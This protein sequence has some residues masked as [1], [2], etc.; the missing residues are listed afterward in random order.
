MASKS[1]IKS[2]I[3]R[4]LNRIDVHANSLDYPTIVTK[5]QSVIDEFSQA[6]EKAGI[7]EY[8]MRT[9]LSRLVGMGCMYFDQ[10]YEVVRP[11]FDQ[12]IQFPPISLDEEIGSQTVWCQ[13]L[14]RERRFDEAR[15]QMRE[16]D[17]LLAKLSGARRKW[18]DGVLSTMREE[19]NA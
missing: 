18:L 6:A 4:A 12:L 8:L 10:P 5:Y 3:G 19:L 1:K 16:L 2:G 11:F 13:Y 17:R 14:I 7:A 15:E 9:V